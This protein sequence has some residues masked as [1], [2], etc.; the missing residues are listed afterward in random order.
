[1]KPVQ[2]ILSGEVAPGVL[3]LD[4][5]EGG[6]SERYWQYEVQPATGAVRLVKEEL[7]QDL[8]NIL[9][10]IGFRRSTGKNFLPMIEHHFRTRARRRFPI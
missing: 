1:M 8:S 3:L 10:Q 5:L 7:F 6:Q 4:V 9:R 2:D